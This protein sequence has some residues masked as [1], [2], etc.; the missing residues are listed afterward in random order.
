METLSAIKWFYDI[1]VPQWLICIS[2]QLVSMLS[3]NKKNAILINL[4]RNLLDPRIFISAVESNDM[5]CFVLFCFLC[6][7][8]S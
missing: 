7:H 6:G 4:V 8:P 5:F 1:G 3:R 2:D